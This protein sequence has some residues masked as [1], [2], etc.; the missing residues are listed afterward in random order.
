MATA[1]VRRRIGRALTALWVWAAA[2]L[3]A[4]DCNRNGVEDRGDILAGTSLDCNLNGVPDECDV[5]ALRSVFRE[6]AVSEIGP[7]RGD[8]VVAD[9]DGDGDPDVV[10]MGYEWLDPLSRWICLIENSGG[11]AFQ[12]RGCL[13]LEGFLEGCAPADIDADGDLDIL[14]CDIKQDRVLVLENRGDLEF[15]LGASIAVSSLPDGVAAGDMDDDGDLDLVITSQ[16]HSQLAIVENLGD[17]AF[18]E[19]AVIDLGY[20]YQPV[21]MSLE[22]LDGDGVLDVLLS[23]SFYLHDSSVLVLLNSGDGR[24]RPGPP[25]STGTFPIPLPGIDLDGDGAIDFLVGGSPPVAVPIVEGRPRAPRQVLATGSIVVADMNN[26]GDVDY[27]LPFVAGGG[28]SYHENLGDDTFA[29]IRVPEPGIRGEGLAMLTDIEGNGLLDV[30]V[31]RSA[32]GGA[33]LK[34]MVHE[35]A[36]THRDLDGDG[37][38][39]DCQWP[40][41]DCNANS[42]LDAEDIASGRSEDCN[43]N[44]VPDECDI[45]PE[46]RLAAPRWLPAASMR[47]DLDGDGILDGLELRTRTAGDIAL[48]AWLLDARG[49]ARPVT[50][51]P[52]DSIY[53]RVT[54]DDFDGDDLPDLA[55]SARGE[56]RIHAGRGDGSFELRSRAPIEAQSLLFLL[57]L[58]IDGDGDLDLLLEPGEGGETSRYAVLTNQG[59]GM[60][61]G[62]FAGSPIS[63]RDQWI[64]AGD[65]D[66]DGLADL[67][68]LHVTGDWL[69]GRLEV[70]LNSGGGDFSSRVQVLGRLFGAGSVVIADFDGDGDPDIITDD[71]QSELSLVDLWRNGGDGDMSRERL[72]YLSGPNPDPTPPPIGIDGLPRLGTIAAGDFDANGRLDIALL[73]GD[74]TSWTASNDSIGGVREGGVRIFLQHERHLAFRESERVHFGILESCSVLECGDI[75]GDGAVDLL[76]GSL[77]IHG[78]GDGTFEGSRTFE[79][80][81]EVAHPVAGDFTGDGRVDLAVV[82][83]Y[84]DNARIVVLTDIAEGGFE[85]VEAVEIDPYPH[86]LLRGDFDGDGSLDLLLVESSRTRL[87]TYLNRGEAGLAAGD[88]QPLPDGCSL[89]GAADFTGDGLDDLVI[90]RN[91]L[92]GTEIWRNEG[93][94]RFLPVTSFEGDV[95]GYTMSSQVAAGDFDGDGA[96]DF[97]LVEDSRPRDPPR[98]AVVV[99]RQLGALVFERV[100]SPGGQLVRS[101]AQPALGVGDL[102]RDGRDDIIVAWQQRPQQCGLSLLFGA[103]AGALRRGPVYEPGLLLSMSDPRWAQVTSGDIDGDGWPD[104]V[105]T[106]NGGVGVSVLDGRPPASPPSFDID[107]D[108]R[109][110]ECQSPVPFVRGDVDQDRRIDITDAL[111][112][113]RAFFLAGPEPLCAKAADADDSGGIDLADPVRILGYL[114]LSA[115]DL[116]RPFPGCGPD[117]TWDELDCPEH[118]AC[119]S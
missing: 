33:A 77:E 102:D 39:D 48:A 101:R 113:L 43:A 109:P 62:P 9:F 27:V 31:L 5:G 7:V 114:F 81:A 13:P 19:P 115:G 83:D 85:V 37:R 50:Q 54:C 104:V 63:L 56:I 105:V 14:V 52:L 91:V 93:G 73:R 88:L 97:A 1:H 92:H 29:E 45:R 42:V 24:L 17:G 78:R 106:G 34:A 72:L 47:V 41:E 80:T 40:A 71:S 68:T 16:V 70:R 2:E 82:T 65:F 4:A 26:D 94:G 22:D 18:G 98:R 60:F 107:G 86:H 21:G 69:Q 59:G 51:L 110:D 25:V 55:I 119:G 95:R 100:E 75:D 87:R 66:G 116:P 35:L 84:R 53:D 76:L 64:Q 117:P 61:Q 23:S 15:E 49:Q 12:P 103:A 79:L 58:D 111:F 8:H 108:G 36:A 46:P 6:G 20:P 96:M 30:I 89:F 44:G 67:V 57:P 90:I 38:P 99:W 11:G 28:C 10:L 74:V 118:Q 112:L 32:E 3:S